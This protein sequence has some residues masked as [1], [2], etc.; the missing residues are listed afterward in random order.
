MLNLS[1]KTSIRKM[2][3]WLAGASKNELIGVCLQVNKSG[4]ARVPVYGTKEQLLT[5]LE[6]VD[7]DILDNAIDA[8]FPDDDL[9]ETKEREP[10]DA[11]DDDGE[12]DTDEN[13]DESETD[14]DEDEDHEDESEEE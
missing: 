3:E 8:V 11:D 2:I 5:G 7:R 4:G 1:K 14:E 9:A 10:S 13:E 12:D 6:G